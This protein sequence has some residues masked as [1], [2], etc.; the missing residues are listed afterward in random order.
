MKDNNSYPALESIIMSM[1]YKAK[2]SFGKG[3]FKSL[4]FVQ[5][6]NYPFSFKAGIILAIHDE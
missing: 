1:Y 5:H 6:L 2:L 3:L 4:K